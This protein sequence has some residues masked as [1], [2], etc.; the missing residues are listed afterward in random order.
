[1]SSEL[2][3]FRCASCEEDVPLANKLMHAIQCHKHSQPDPASLPSKHDCAVSL[4]DSDSTG[5]AELE[6][7]GAGS[8]TLLETPSAEQGEASTA[9]IERKQDDP[10]NMLVTCEFCDIEV[11]LP[12]LSEHAYACGSRTDVCEFCMCYVRLCDFATHRI[13]G[14]ASGATAS[15]MPSEMLPE[16]APLLE[17]A[18]TQQ[19]HRE[20]QVRLAEHEIPRW[21]PVLIA[22]AGVGAAVAFSTLARRR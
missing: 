12:A 20:R 8:T 9:S 21:A 15:A 19:Y 1:M 18:P 11:P 14:C 6:H 4:N 2:D 5:G 16:Q 10:E 7:Q 22:A 13:S 17:P 3:I